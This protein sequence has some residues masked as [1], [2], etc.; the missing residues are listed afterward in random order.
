MKNSFVLSLIKKWSRVL[1]LALAVTQVSDTASA[2]LYAP[3]DIATNLTFRAR[4]TFTH[5]VGGTN[6]AVGAE[7]KLR[8]FAGR[9]VFLEWF[10]V[11]C[12]FCTAAV[13]QVDSGIVDWY[14]A[15]GGNPY[16]VPVFYLFVNQESS[17]SFQTQTTSYVNAN[18]DSSTVVLNDY[19]AVGGPWLV[20]PAFQN[21]GQPIFAIINGVTNSPSH[22]PWQVLVNYLG[23]GQTDFNA[24]L[25]SFRTIIDTVQPPVLAPLMTNAKRIGADFE[26][27]FQTQ[28]GRSYRVL[29]STNLTSW[30]TLKTI[31]GTNIPTVFRH[32][33]AP[34]SR[35][36]YRVV[37]P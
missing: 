2:A 10:A 22:Q 1:L 33:N 4:R 18:L 24:T 5:P 7:V 19:A 11:W 12:P 14:A 25:A 23:F 36:F 29:G 6:V 17:S 35:Q 8:D 34:P 15:R 30:T 21:S 26:F 37:T 20:R 13:P 28:L 3:G 16:G 31:G 32:T 9:I 27:N